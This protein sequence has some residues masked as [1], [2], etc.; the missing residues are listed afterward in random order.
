MH[1]TAFSFMRRKIAV[2][3]KKLP[4]IFDFGVVKNREK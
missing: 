3:G 4:K 2:C 1:E